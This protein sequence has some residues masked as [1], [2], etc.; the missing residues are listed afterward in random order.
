MGNTE[1]TFEHT[2]TDNIICP[3]CDWEDTDSWEFGTEDGTHTCGN[4]EEEFRVSP[5][6][7]VTYSTYRMDCEE[8]GKKHDYQLLE[9]CLRDREYKDRKWINLPESK[10][11]YMK[12]EQCTICGDKNYID[13]TKEEYLKNNNQ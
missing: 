3:Y 2:H 7:S 11:R 13:I 10:Y 9:Y 1:I 6:V 5:C 4:C 12:I 8:I